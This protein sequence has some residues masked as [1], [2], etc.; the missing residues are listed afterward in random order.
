MIDYKY[1]NNR[2]SGSGAMMEISVVVHESVLVMIV[3]VYVHGK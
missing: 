3:I 1:E 2:K